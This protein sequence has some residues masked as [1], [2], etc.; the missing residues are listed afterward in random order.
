MSLLKNQH[1]KLILISGLLVAIVLAVS[2]FVFL[3]QIRSELKK[4]HAKDI[5]QTINQL[6]SAN[7]N[8]ENANMQRIASAERIAAMYLTEVVEIWESDDSMNIPSVIA[9]NGSLGYFK[10]PRLKS[11]DAD[12]YKNNDIVNTIQYLTN[13][14]VCLWQKQ[15]DGYIRITGNL[16]EAIG[17]KAYPVFVHFGTPMVQHVEAGKKFIERKTTPFDSELSVFR[18]LILS[19]GI[20]LI[21]Q[22]SIEEGTPIALKRLFEDN[23]FYQNKQLFF[24]N[25]DDSTIINTELNDFFRNSALTKRMRLHKSDFGTLEESRYV[26]GKMQTYT[27]SFVKTNDSERFAGIIYPKENYDDGIRRYVYLI[28]ILFTIIGLVVVAIM[29][30]V[31]F[32][33]RK[34]LLKLQKVLRNFATGNF[35]STKIK[36]NYVDNSKQSI[37]ESVHEISSYIVQ[38]S[39]YARALSIGNYDIEIKPKSENDVIGT[40]LNLL[41]N[42][43]HNLRKKQAELSE[44]EALRQK[45]TAG[46]NE[47]NAILQYATDS[48]EFFTKLLHNITNFLEIQQAGL[49]AVERP[50]EGSPYMEL[51]AH[52]AYGQK[53]LALRQVGSNEGL[54]GLCFQEKKRIVLKEIPENYTKIQSGFG[55][56]DPESIVLVPMIFNTE[57]QAVI[58]IAATYDIEEYKIGFMESIG[59]SIASTLSNINNTRRTSEL[60][61][62]TKEQ[63]KQIETQR[64]ELQERIDTHRRQNRKLDKELLDTQEIIKSIK[65]SGHI[66]EYTVDGEIISLSE[67]SALLVG[68]SPEQLI[69][70]KYEELFDTSA[71][72]KKRTQQWKDLKAG[73]T[74]ETVEMLKQTDGNIR[75]VYA[76]YLP[77]RDARR[78]I[79]RVLAILSVHFEEK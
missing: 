69:G 64:I 7:Q 50:D 9:E 43:L 65:D 18:P 63:A 67:R 79:Y 66:I 20:K 30:F 4:Q 53:R 37:S 44:S 21:L 70:K 14:Y 73:K 24:L 17:P 54:V 2:A 78:K 34:F 39:D 16:P 42:D 29:H 36:T 26:S 6:K 57:V 75:K 72:S 76:L 41:R 8:H 10:L 12:L 62:Q 28:A 52:Y 46:Q 61:E 1:T 51:K 59:E 55:E 27:V 25:K 15:K 23:R 60:L 22:I 19:G 49:F 68:T 56:S 13:T 3:S 5:I 35:E 38:N 74:V 32:S 40:S 31:Y 11:G 71:N 48:D 45:L 77:I 58:E 47:I 33:D